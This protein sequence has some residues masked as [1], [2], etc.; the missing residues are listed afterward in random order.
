MISIDNEFII[1]MREL[2]R[3]EIRI[4][5]EEDCFQEIIDEGIDKLKEKKDD[6]I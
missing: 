4:C 1:A 2:I 3:D 5:M 6:S